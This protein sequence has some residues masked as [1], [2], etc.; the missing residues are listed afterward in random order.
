MDMSLQNP[1]SRAHLKAWWN[2]FNFAQK[3][4]K[5]SEAAKGLLS[6]Y[7]PCSDL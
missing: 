4:K 6:A 1:P 5:E 2:S 3:V 7:L